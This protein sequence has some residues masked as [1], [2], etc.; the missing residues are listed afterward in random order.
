V[1]TIVTLECKMGFQQELWR[2]LEI[3]DHLDLWACKLFRSTVDMY[4]M[5][6]CTHH[7]AVCLE[8]QL[9]Y[10]SVFTPII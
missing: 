9:L 2:S 3:A 1:I 4:E 7:D 10:I 6:R 8:S 5:K